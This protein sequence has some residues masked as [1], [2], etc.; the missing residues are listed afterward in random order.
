MNIRIPGLEGIDI[1]EVLGRV[2]QSRPPLNKKR[3]LP[4][5]PLNK[6][7]PLPVSRPI[8]SP[9]ISGGFPGGIGIGG[10]QLGERITGPGSFNKMFGKG[11]SS[12]PD[13]PVEIP[14]IINIPGVGPIQLPKAVDRP[15]SVADEAPLDNRMPFEIKNLELPTSG[16]RGINPPL[17]KRADGSTIYLMDDD[18]FDIL[19]SREIDDPYAGYRDREDD[20]D[21]DT[22]PVDFQQPSDYLSEQEMENITTP[23][24]SL[25][26]EQLRQLYTSG[27]MDYD[28]D[29]F[30][31]TEGMF[32][33]AGQ[34]YGLGVDQD[35]ID[36]I[37]EEINFSSNQPA[38]TPAPTP[39][40]I[41]APPP[42]DPFKDYVPRNILGTSFDPKDVSYQKQ[43]VADARA[44]MT[45]GANIQG[46]G[47]LTYDN[48]LLGNKQTQFSGYGQPMP[49]APLMNYAGLASPKT[50]STPPPDPDKEI[51]R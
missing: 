18:A 36:E 20:D 46:G 16:N 25:T 9:I 39:A 17:G 42:P 41:K 22:P 43:Q 2:P 49:T 5:P 44:R 11:E 50:Y 47:Y 26:E 38:P 48:P 6:K 28:D 37:A 8:D 19:E 1:D 15:I 29:Y 4:K 32:G 21:E 51:I 35:R 3:P 23:N 13:V 14:K 40:P 31:D 12:K 10:A 33:E 45:P 24:P 7:R 27:M 30:T 34:R